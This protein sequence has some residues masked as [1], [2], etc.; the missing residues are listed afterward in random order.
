MRSTLNVSVSEIVTVSALVVVLRVV[1]V[2]VVVADD[3]VPAVVTPVCVRTSEEPV[4][5][6]VVE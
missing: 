1:L 3:T 4:E 2:L 6:V 5:V